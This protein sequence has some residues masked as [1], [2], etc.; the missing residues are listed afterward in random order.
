[1]GVMTRSFPS[2]KRGDQDSIVDQRVCILAGYDF[3][4]EEP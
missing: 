2:V 1:M 3:V 4:L